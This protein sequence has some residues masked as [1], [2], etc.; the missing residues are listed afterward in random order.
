MIRTDLKQDDMPKTWY[1]ILPDLPE[2]LPPPVDETGKAL[3][4]LKLAM[5]SRVLEYEFSRER[6]PEIPD[7]IY[8]KYMQIGRPTPIIRAKKLEEYLGNSVRIYLKMESYTYSGSHKINSAL[9]HVYFAT[10]D[11]A[12]FVSTETG[13]GQWGSAVALASALF[14]IPAHIFMVRA[15]FYAKPYR[16]YLMEMY[17]ADAHPSPSDFTP[18]GRE[19]LKQLPDTS[20]SLGISISEA[21]HYALENG[22]KYVAGSVINSDILF[23]TI[24]GM[25]AKK[26]MEMIDVDPDYI[27]GVV[28]G[29]SNYAALAFPFLGDELR[30]GHVKRKYIAA[31][32][33]E[34]PK[35]TEG[36]YRYDYPDTGKVLPMLKMFTLGYQFIPPA[37]YA[38]GLRYHAVAPTLSLLM[39]RGIVE[40][41]DYNQDEA[42]RW[43]KLF[44][45]L[46]GYIPA[47]ETSHALPIIKEI[48]DKAKKEG[49]VKNVLVSFS[50]HGLLD[51]ANYAEAMGFK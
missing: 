30:K 20:G 4:T 16:K 7:A 2:D 46:E 34:V 49:T 8:E 27:V 3:E 11:N 24:A 50:G 41:R 14:R 38:G 51:L 40:S 23:K 25:E 15:S 17:G 31:G 42:F 32:S 47:P 21:I 5:P 35:M 48:A 9:A 33:K 36:E 26:Q 19:V 6:Y 1:N 22:G 44:S 12:K 39:N 13:A 37:V 45:E 28:G 18:Y 43:A 10:E 29:G